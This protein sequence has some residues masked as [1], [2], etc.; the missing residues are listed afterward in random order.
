MSIIKKINKITNYI[1]KS[2]WFLAYGVNRTLFYY[3]FWH[4]QLRRKV[5]YI[6]KEID[7][8]VSLYSIPKSGI[9]IFFI[10]ETENHEDFE[11]FEALTV[12][13]LRVMEL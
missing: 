5:T 1:C 11:R 12:K 6:Q 2:V 7:K 8:E 10:I 4:N 13:C 9:T 3:L